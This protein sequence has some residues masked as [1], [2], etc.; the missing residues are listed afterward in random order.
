MRL[1]VLMLPALLVAAPG[2]TQV[3]LGGQSADAAGQAAGRDVLGSRCSRDRDCWPEAVCIGGSCERECVTDFECATSNPGTLPGTYQCKDWRCV[4]ASATPTPAVDAGGAPPRDTGRPAPDTYAPAP[5][6]GPGA[7]DPGTPQT[8]DGCGPNGRDYGQ[9]CTCPSSCKSGLCAGATGGNQGF[10]TDRCNTAKDCPGTHVC[11]DIGGG[12][13]ICA[14]SDA[15]KQVDCNTGVCIAGLNLPDGLGNC[16]CTVE[17]VDGKDC[18]SNASC[19]L[20]ATPGGNRKLCMPIGQTCDSN[21]PAKQACYG[22]CVSIGG[23][24]GFCTT[25]CNTGADCPAPWTC[26]A[27]TVEGTGTQISICKNP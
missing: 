16:V 7:I 23:G 17:C 14:K 3:D 9:A 24:Q 18:P 2:C 10:C 4:P 8:D 27:A 15:G 6:P 12:S 26:E 19:T 1:L 21:N 20:V 11:Y 22:F 25:Q 13:R 5:D